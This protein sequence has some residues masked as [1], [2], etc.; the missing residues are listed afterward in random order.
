[1]KIR[2]LADTAIVAA[3]LMTSI[4]DLNIHLTPE[5]LLTQAA[6]SAS[7]PVTAPYEPSDPC[8]NPASRELCQ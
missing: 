5:D 3:M 8:D 7:V 1:M 2:K 4:P 6:R